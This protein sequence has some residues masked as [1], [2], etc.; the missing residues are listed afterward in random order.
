MSSCAD[1]EEA[2]LLIDLAID[3]AKLSG[4]DVNASELLLGVVQ[5]RN[6]DG[7]D[8]NDVVLR[9]CK[10][11]ADVNQINRWQPYQNRSIAEILIMAH[12]KYHQALETIKYYKGSNSQGGQSSSDNPI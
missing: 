1:A 2:D 5:N 3:C 10:M 9:L 8:L 11:G 4:Q 12:M 7:A 6:I